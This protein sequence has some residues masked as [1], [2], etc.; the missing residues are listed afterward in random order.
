VHADFSVPVGPVLQPDRGGQHVF[1]HLCAVHFTELR[2]ALI[3]IA[4]I[5]T[6]GR[7]TVGRERVEAF[8]SEPSSDVFDVGIQTAILVNDQ[9]AG[10]LGVCSCRCRTSELPFDIAVTG[11]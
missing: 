5:T 6:N 8:E 11:R 4:G 3:F 2:L 1:L 10:Q 9:N 7:E